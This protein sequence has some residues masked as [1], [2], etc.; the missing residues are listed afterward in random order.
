MVVNEILLMHTQDCH[1]C[2]QAEAMLGALELPYRC[3]EITDKPEWVETYG[4]RVPVLV[5]DER[6]LGWPFE[7]QQVVDFVRDAQ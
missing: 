5:Q 6:E 2:E 4:I 7:P 3:C 1:L